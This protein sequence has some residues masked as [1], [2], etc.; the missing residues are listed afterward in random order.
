MITS[1]C[2]SEDTRFR[3]VIPSLLAIFRGFAMKMVP[4][5]FIDCQFF[6]FKMVGRL[7]NSGASRL[8]L[9]GEFTSEFTLKYAVIRFEVGFIAC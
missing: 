9:I 7:L 4:Y 1:K 3:F 6:S 5:A 2:I 8:Q